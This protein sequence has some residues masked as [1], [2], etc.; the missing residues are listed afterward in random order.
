MRA[1]VLSDIHG[2][3][4]LARR[5]L[6]KEDDYDV[7]FICGDITDFG[8]VE[9]AEEMLFEFSEFG[10]IY[11][12]P[13]NCDPP[14]L[15]HLIEVGYESLHGRTVNVGGV[16]I[17]GIGGSVITPFNTPFELE[18]SQIRA[19]LRGIGLN[20]NGILVSHCPPKGVLDSV[21]GGR[22][23]GSIAIREFIERK[24]PDYCFCGHIHESKGMSKLG[25]TVVVNVGP[26]SLGYYCLFDSES[27]KLVHRK[28]NKNRRKSI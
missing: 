11:F 21:S 20:G 19:L 27:G 10:K 25:K 7:I 15:A 6:E 2:K 22:R 16:K 28:F 12:V 1:I 23:G 17:G 26:A 14:K 3:Y 4:D 9:E 5:I 8:S 13:G 18:E 24:Q